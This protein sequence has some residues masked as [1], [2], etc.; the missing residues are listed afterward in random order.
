[1]DE[2]LQI[3]KTIQNLSQVYVQDINEKDEVLQKLIQKG[4]NIIDIYEETTTNIVVGA[5]TFYALSE[6][7]S[8]LRVTKSFKD[9]K[10]KDDLI[11]RVF[12]IIKKLI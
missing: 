4:I 10:E 11:Y 12:T 7:L 8:C 2:L 1:M 9:V 6:F 3:S 5:K